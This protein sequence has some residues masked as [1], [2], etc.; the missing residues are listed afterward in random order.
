[1]LR[2]GPSKPRN[3]FS[4]HVHAVRMHESVIGKDK[5]EVAMCGAKFTLASNQ[6]NIVDCADCRKLLDERK[7]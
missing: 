2:A 5:T 7:K 4:W 1:M 3:G 6:Y